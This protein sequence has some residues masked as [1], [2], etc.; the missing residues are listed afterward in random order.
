MSISTPFIRR[1]VA[2]SLLMAAILMAGIISYPALP[3][4]PLPQVDFPTILVSASVLA[5]CL[6]ADLKGSF[7]LLSQTDSIT[8]PLTRLAS[9]R[10]MVSTSGSSGINTV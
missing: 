4:A 3:I 7:L 1:P 8:S 6:G 9:P 2:T 5:I 10:A